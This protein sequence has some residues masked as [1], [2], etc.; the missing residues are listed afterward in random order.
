[1]P[2]AATMVTA[3]PIGKRATE[4]EIIKYME[5]TTNHSSV[6]SH[7]YLSLKA[8]TFSVNQNIGREPN[9][10]TQRVPLIKR[11]VRYHVRHSFRGKNMFLFLDESFGW[12]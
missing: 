7:F 9:T 11:G 2:P 6:L 8:Q 4:E 3:T 1:M 12:R 10:H 5:M